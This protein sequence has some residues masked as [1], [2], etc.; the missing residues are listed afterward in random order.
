VQRTLQPQEAL[1]AGSWQAAA[2]AWTAHGWNNSS[3]RHQ[4]FFF[5]RTS[6]RW[7]MD[8]YFNGHYPLL[9]LSRFDMLHGCAHGLLYMS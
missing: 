4:A 3:N 1:A 6:S 8:V 2:A 9:H 7:M 5:A